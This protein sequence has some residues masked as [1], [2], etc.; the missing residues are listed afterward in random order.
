MMLAACSGEKH[1]VPAEE[2][3]SPDTGKVEG[4]ADTA[5][6]ETPTP[7][8]AADKLFDDFIY[9]FMKNDHFQLSRISFPLANIVDGR[10]HP[11]QRQQWKHDY[12]FSREDFYTMIFDNKAGEEAEKDSA[13]HDVTVEWVYLDR[14]RVKQYI[15]KKENGAW[16]LTG[17]NSHAL[18]KN[19]NSEFYRFYNRFANDSV[20]QRAHISNPFAFSTY[21]TDNF[22][23]IEGVLDVD[24]WVDFRPELPRH[25]ITNINYGQAYRPTGYRILMLN[26]LSGGMNCTLEFKKRKGEWMLVRLEN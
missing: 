16:M 23:D 1:E 19:E 9:A 8:Q 24:Q 21:D 4:A 18:S 6:A 25:V 5:I 22:E 11:I 3:A 2:N 26:S 13:V 7:P 14:N 17:L 20:F 12:M 10:N 15:F